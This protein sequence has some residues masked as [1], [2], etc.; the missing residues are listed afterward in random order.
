MGLSEAPRAR[1][2]TIPHRRHRI[3]VAGL[4]PAAVARRPR[5]TVSLSSIPCTYSILSILWS[6][7]CNLIEPY[8]RE[9]AG[10][11]AAHKP[12]RLRT[13]SDLFRPSPSTTRTST[14]PLGP[15][16]SHPAL[17][18]TSLAAG[19]ILFPLREYCYKGEG[20]RFERRKIQGGFCEV[21]DS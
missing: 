12:D 15:P 13:R 19:A 17:H 11:L 16:R 21:N 1:D 3:D 6:S 10:A 5:S 2:W 14:W 18:R 9:K 7:M 8:R 4:Q 20:A